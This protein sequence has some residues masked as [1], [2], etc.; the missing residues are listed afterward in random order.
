MQRPIGNSGGLR[1]IHKN[2]PEGLVEVSSVLEKIDVH[3][4]WGHVTYKVVGV[5]APNGLYQ[6][7]F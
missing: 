5:D 2:V 6:S 1:T 4:S 3:L 7:V